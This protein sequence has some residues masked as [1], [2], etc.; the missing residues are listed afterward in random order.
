MNN[1]NDNTSLFDLIFNIALGL[2]LMFMVSVIVMKQGNQKTNVKTKAEFTIILTWQDGVNHDVDLWV[3]DPQ[4]NVT[5][6]KS[7]ENGVTHL[8]RDDFGMTN[9]YYVENGEK[10]YIMVKINL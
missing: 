6:F 9:D 4:K 1:Q 10:I 2:C 8:D 7:K 3:R 5:S